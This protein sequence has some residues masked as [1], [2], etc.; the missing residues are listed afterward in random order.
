VTSFWSEPLKFLDLAGRGVC[1][2][3]KVFRGSLQ[4]EVTDTPSHQ[5]GNKA[6]VV[7]PIEGAHRIR[8]YVLPRYAMFFPGDNE[9]RHAK[10]IAPRR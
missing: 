6:F 4:K 1:G 10:L 5:I 8:T 9:G 2:D 7:E 3:V